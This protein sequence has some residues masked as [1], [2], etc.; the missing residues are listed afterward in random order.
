[1]QQ[2]WS[3]IL[4]GEANTPGSFAKRTVNLLGDLEKTDAE[5]FNLLCCFG[6]TFDYF[7]PLVFDV[8]HTIYRGHGITFASLSHLETLGLVRFD[9]LGGFVR[10]KL[11]RT[12]TVS[13]YGRTLDLRLAK[14]DENDLPVGNVM[15]TRAGLELARVCQTEAVEGFFEYVHDQWAASGL[16]PKSGS[17]QGPPASS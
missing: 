12:V 11:P 9:P 6:W 17:E 13:Y 16:V 3:R 10:T 5:L 4:A 15:M 7:M 2:L 8:K 1:M 14:D